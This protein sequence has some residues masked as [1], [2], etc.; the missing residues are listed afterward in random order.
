MSSEND[1]V[2]RV[3]EYGNKKD[4][5]KITAL[6]EE[7]LVSYYKILSSYGI[8]EKIPEERIF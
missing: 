8:V 6:E 1:K 3:T 4:S 5:G 7:E 2:I